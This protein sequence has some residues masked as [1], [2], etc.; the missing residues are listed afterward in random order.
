MADRGKCKYQGQSVRG[1]K[2]RIENYKAPDISADQLKIIEK[3][4]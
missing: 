1:C 3:Y 2:K 4:L